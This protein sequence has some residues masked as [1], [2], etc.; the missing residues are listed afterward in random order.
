MTTAL[1]SAA[2][3]IVLTVLLP[4][5]AAAQP[6]S[7]IQLVLNQ[8]FGRALFRQC[9][10]GVVVYE[11]AGSATLWCVR[12]ARPPSDLQHH[13]QLSREEAARV[14]KLA[15]ESDLFSGPDIGSD[16]TPVDGIFETL[17]V[18]EA[19]RTTI[20][21]TSGNETFAKGSR[22]TL[23]SLLQALLR[24]LQKSASAGKAL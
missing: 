7:S 17:K 14:L 3:A 8:E 10:L 15:A 1:R 2:I 12:N 16:S 9:R 24:E 19:E 4:A 22:A 21:V 18:T 20:M 13:R 6:R 5:A 11:G 23:L